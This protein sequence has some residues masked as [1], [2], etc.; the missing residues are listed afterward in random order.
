MDKPIKVTLD[1][2]GIPVRC[3]FNREKRCYKSVI[4]RTTATKIHKVASGMVS[5]CKHPGQEFN[6]SV[7]VRFGGG[8]AIDRGFRY[9]IREIHISRFVETDP[10]DPSFRGK[11]DIECF[12]M[13]IDMW[14]VATMDCTLTVSLNMFDWMHAERMKV[15]RAG[16]LLT[17]EAPVLA[18]EERKP[19]GSS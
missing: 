19:I 8:S 13:D 10:T 4:S 18:E 1:C 17:Q 14:S 9:Y 3:V 7:G 6:V 16:N 11:S 5:Q 2:L 15:A 12:T